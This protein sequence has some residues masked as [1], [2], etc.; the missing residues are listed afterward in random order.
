M[1]K[2]P[3]ELLKSFQP[4]KELS[5]LVMVFSIIT[6]FQV[7]TLP[8]QDLSALY[9][10]V[11][12]AVVV[13]E[14]EKQEIESSGGTSVEVTVGGLGTGFLISDT[15]VVTAAHVVQTAKKILVHFSDNEEI[16]GK[17]VVSFKNA[18]VA[19]VE[20]IWPR[21]NPVTVPFGNSDEAKVG[22][23]I[24]VIGAP[25]G[26]VNSLSSGYISGRLQGKKV[27]NPFSKVE[28]F[29]TDA[30]INTGNSGGPMFNMKGEVIGVVSYIL[31]QSGGFEGLGFA[32][33]SNIAQEL[34]FQEQILWAGI[35]A[36]LLTGEMAKIF[37]L[38]Q[39]HGI[40][41]QKV[42]FDSPLG[43]MGVQGGTYTATI[44]D[45]EIIVGGD[46]IL[47]IDGIRFSTSDQ[48]LRQL[49]DHLKKR[50]PQDPLVI[51]VLRSGK[52]VELT[53]NK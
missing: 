37:N 38:P 27:S 26:L 18:D 53:L 5:N 13:I 40:L 9:E 48:E 46:I 15:Q 6:G 25:M 45:E 11:S 10:R 34:L 41:V 44:E 51:T 36:Y 21:K 32:A 30:A 4:F 33:T 47:E 2:T 29:Q 24:F 8:A 43:L 42:V 19:L 16:P 1:N 17:V 52:M 3:F 49:A 23:Q 22:Q 12:P 28:Y 50:K 35:D 14:T 7:H 31:S 20:L 39:P